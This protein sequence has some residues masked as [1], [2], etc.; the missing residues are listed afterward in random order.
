[1]D[2]ADATELM[3]SS[4]ARYVSDSK[5]SLKELSLPG[6][7]FNKLMEYLDILNIASLYSKMGL[8][9]SIYSE[10]WKVPQEIISEMATKVPRQKFYFPKKG[11]KGSGKYIKKWNMIIPKSYL[12]RFPHLA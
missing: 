4:S 10:Q 11:S 6:I 3:S 8:L 7:S 12:M 5:F 9:L 2:F 1:M